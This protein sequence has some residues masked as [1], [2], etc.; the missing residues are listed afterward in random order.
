MTEHNPEFETELSKHDRWNRRLLNVIF[1]YFGTPANYLDVGSGTGA[2]VNAA[3]EMGVDAYGVDLMAGFSDYIYHH[4]LREPFDHG[5]KYQLITCIET[6]E[7]IDA[8]FA[9]VLVESIARHTI[10]GSILFWTA[11]G[12]GQDG[13]D[14]KNCVL[15][16]VW[17]DMFYQH[18]LSYR[19]D[20]TVK[21]QMAINLLV[22][23]PS[24][25]LWIGNLQI[26]DR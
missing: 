1:A 14:H 13:I 3:R 11:A 18:G 26:F 20:Y 24:R 22:P 19:Q 6:V 23:S 7:H 21:M 4:D 17:R 2:M 15:G 16:S 5:R 12:P 8:P 10:P 9:H 25:D